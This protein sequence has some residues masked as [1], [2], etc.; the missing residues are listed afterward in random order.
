MSLTDA[1]RTT[2]SERYRDSRVV[3]VYEESFACPGP[4]DCRTGYEV[5]DAFAELVAEGFMTH[6]VQRYCENGHVAWAGPPQDHYPTECLYCDAADITDAVDE[7]CFETRHV[8]ALSESA[9]AVLKLADEGAAGVDTTALA[10]QIRGWPLW[11]Q[12]ILRSLLGWG[13]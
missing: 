6:T 1:I 9:Q 4:P 12:N 2:V 13:L 7:D 11:K 8:Y 10:V 3:L 5:R